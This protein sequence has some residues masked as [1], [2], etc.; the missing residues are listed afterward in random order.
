M[1]RFSIENDSLKQ[2]GHVHK[3]GVPYNMIHSEVI[4]DSIE[5]MQFFPF[6]RCCFSIGDWGIISG[7]PRVF[8]QKY[9]HLQFM[10][11]KP[12]WIRKVFGN[13][14]GWSY[15]GSDP[16]DAVEMVFA[17]NPYV[18]WFDVG[19]F[20][21]VITDHDR[22]YRYEN[23]PL[24]EQIMGY[25]G[26]AENELNY[27]TYD[28]RPDIYFSNEEITIGQQIINNY[29]GSTNQYG[30]LLFASRLEHLNNCWPETNKSIQ[31]LIN[32]IR[33][34]GYDRDYK[35]FYYSSFPLDKSYWANIFNIDIGNTFVDFATIP[36]CTQRIQWYIKSQAKFNISYQAGFND[37]ITRYSDHLIATHRIGTGET[38]MRGVTYFQND[39]AII[40]YT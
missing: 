37:T 29:I 13:V 12:N 40:K 33:Q 6:T 32:S 9:P 39:G 2:H 18:K 23:E 25:F 15:Q 22:S 34:H 31:N 28:H 7:L 16:A 27:Q 19:E 21:N 36:N 35:I 8:K 24:A 3:L 11:P 17:N 20:T 10:V 1:V 30:C 38:T 4:R 26:F 5:S 14:G